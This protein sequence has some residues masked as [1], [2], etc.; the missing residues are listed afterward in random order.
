MKGNKYTVRFS[1][2][3]KDGHTFVI[4]LDD[5]QRLTQEGMFIKILKEISRAGV[6]LRIEELEE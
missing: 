5:M 1:E 3:L 4:T 6:R 2:E